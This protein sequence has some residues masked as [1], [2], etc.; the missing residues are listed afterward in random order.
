MTN[1]AYRPTCIGHIGGTSYGADF[2]A[3]GQCPAPISDGVTGYSAA[4]IR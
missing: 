4:E 2:N 3:M 1:R